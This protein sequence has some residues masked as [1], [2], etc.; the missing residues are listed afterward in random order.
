MSSGVDL[1]ATRGDWDPAPGL[2]TA[3]DD[4]PALPLALSRGVAGRRVGGRPEGVRRSGPVTRGDGFEAAGVAV[5]RAGS[6]T[7]G[8]LA[9][10]VD[11]FFDDVC[12][13]MT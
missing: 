5:S 3:P 11:I 1:S 7:G 6:F 9:G 8:T 12:R 4:G 13:A 2:S 10:V